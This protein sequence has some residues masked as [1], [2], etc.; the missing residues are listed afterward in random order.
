MFADQLV[1]QLESDWRGPPS[2]SLVSC[3]TAAVLRAAE[4]V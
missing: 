2:G 4:A 3:P 1:V